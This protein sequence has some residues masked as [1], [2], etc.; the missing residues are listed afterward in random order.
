[1][2]LG[3]PVGFGFKCFVMIVWV[4]LSL[5]L[6]SDRWVLRDFRVV[7]MIVDFYILGFVVGA[8]FLCFVILLFGFGVCFVI[9]MLEV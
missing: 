6:T 9:T 2:T 3:F 4:D 7:I 1:M 8:N 5:E